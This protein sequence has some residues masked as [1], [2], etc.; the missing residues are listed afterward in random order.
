MSQAPRA[1]VVVTSHDRFGALERRT[2]YW[3][4]EVTHFCHVVGAAGFEVD[5]V[6]PKGGK[7]PLDD[8]S[9]DR[10]DRANQGFIAA[11]QLADKLDAT[12]TPAEV[13]AGRYSVIYF[14]GG[15]GAM[16]DFPESAPLARLAEAIYARG[17]VVSAVC[18]GSAG[19]LP[20]RHADGRPLIEGQPVTG[21]ANLEE[22]LLRLTNHVPYLLEDELKK[23]GGRYRSA[24]IPFTEYVAVGERLVSGQNPRSARAAARAVVE[25]LR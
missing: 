3:L 23:R 18:H 12:M 8:K 9:Q 13:D 4:G 25:L 24:V 15:H 1:L 14:A 2:G 21:F 19:L 20:L 11:P 10:G 5:F 16:W 22:S 17:G 6:S 7:P